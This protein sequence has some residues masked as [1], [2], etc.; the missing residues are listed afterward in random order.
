MLANLSGHSVCGAAKVAIVWAYG[1]AE[2]GRVS[3]VMTVSMLLVQFA[4]QLAMVLFPRLRRESG[5]RRE[6]MLMKLNVAAGLFLPMILLTYLPIKMLVE[7]YLPQYAEGLSYLPI[8]L[9]LCVLEGRAC[10][11]GGTYHKVMR[12]EGRLLKVNLSC[13]AFGFVGCLTS[14]YFGANTHTILLLALVITALRAFLLD[15]NTI[16]EPSKSVGDILSTSALCAVFIASSS[17]ATPFI[18]FVIFT[19]FYLWYLAQ[20]KDDLKSLGLKT[21]QKAA[22]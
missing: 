1:D 11:V 8:L 9:S 13:A 2:F 19:A 22:L 12:L 17:L 3:F 14:A 15:P 4:S 21:K 16:R 5:E 6:T 20:R 7:S 18:S 10:L